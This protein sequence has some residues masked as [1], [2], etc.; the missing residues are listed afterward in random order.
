[1]LYRTLLMFGFLLSALGCNA[2]PIPERLKTTYEPLNTKLSKMLSVDKFT[3]S[4]AEA[5]QLDQPVYLDAREVSEYETSHLP[6]AK[7]LG[8]NKPDFQVL[9]QL[10]KNQNIVVYCTIGYRSEKMVARL[11]KRGFTNVYNLYGSIY[12]WSLSG[13][14]LED[15]EGK[16]TKMV[17]TYNKK[18]GTYFPHDELE[19]Y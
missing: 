15:K 8:F 6:G 9:N 18:W 19:V 5:Q 17:H 3:I 14:P 13:F 11:R 10:D 1:M 16:P 7:M 2:Q 4:P 12:A